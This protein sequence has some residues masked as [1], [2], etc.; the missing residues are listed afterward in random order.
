MSLSKT[1]PNLWH[2]TGAH[3]GRSGQLKTEAAEGGAH[4]GQGTSAAFVRDA[5]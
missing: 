5:G 4:R 1:H 3:V 2:N